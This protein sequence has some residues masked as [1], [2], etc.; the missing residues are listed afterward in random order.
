MEP[1]IV[2][3]S[4]HPA[5]AAAV[6]RELGA[7]LIPCRLGSYPDGERRVELGKP[8]HGRTVALVQPLGPP[9]GEHLLEL[10][11]LSLWLLAYDPPAHRPRN[12]GL[13]PAPP[14]PAAS[15]PP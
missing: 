10:L 6:A 3:G 11:L 1:V 5:L 13:T 14:P 9:V 7:Q 15:G 12:A 4:A 8:V 2:A